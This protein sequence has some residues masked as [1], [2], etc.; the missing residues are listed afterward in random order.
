MLGER[1]QKQMYEFIDAVL[2]E[3]GA[4]ESCTENEKRLGRRLLELW[5][6]LGL[7]TRSESF[8][9]HPRAFLGFIPF[10]ALLYLAATILYWSAPLWGALA[11]FLALVVT[12]VELLRYRELIDPLF[13]V[14]TGENVVG[15]WRPAGKVQRRVVIS[16]HQDSAYE[17]NLWYF[18]KNASIPIMVVGFVAPAV[19][20]LGGLAKWLAGSGAEAPI[21]ETIGWVAMGLYPVVGLNLFFHTYTVVPGA[22][23][24]LAGV[25]VLCGM[26]SA[27][28]DAQREGAPLCNTTE[29]V[30]LAA[31]SEEAGLRGAK[32]YAE[33]HHVEHTAL[34]TFGIF[35]D[36]VYDERHLTVIYRELFTGA[37]HDPRLVSLAKNVAAEHGWPVR[38][39]MIPLGA[40]DA[41]AFTLAGVP[42][43]ALLCQDA[44]KLVPNYH[45]RL[46]TI[47]WVRPQSLSVMLQLVA[48][49]V[50]RI[51]AGAMEK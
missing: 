44:T 3:I 22:M 33:A 5:R 10:A 24:D 19:P 35:V 43:V 37:H 49:M 14:A 12:V 11:A 27:L 25:S 40:T 39:H 36:G 8:T 45:T 42:S 7:E 13:P 6:N 17:F 18:L 29:V 50:R 2:H 47:E 31:S 28:T 15:I 48:D 30:L 9:C 1:Y 23:D 20:F 16:A 26:A 51:D 46:D 34:P 38:Q 21:F 41:T 4:R 32:R